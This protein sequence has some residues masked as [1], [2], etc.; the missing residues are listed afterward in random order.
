MAGPDLYD[1]ESMY[2]LSLTVI[3]MQTS[4]ENWRVCEAG[5]K[6]FKTKSIELNSLT[7]SKCVTDGNLIIY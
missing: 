4:K 3:L 2:I 6:H 1:F 5:E 7:N